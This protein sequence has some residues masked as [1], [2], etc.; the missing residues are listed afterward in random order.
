MDMTD[1]EETTA[2]SSLL[3]TALEA[4]MQRLKAVPLLDDREHRKLQIEASSLLWEQGLKVAYKSLAMAAGRGQI[5]KAVL[6]DEDALQA[7]NLAV[8]TLILQWD[9]D[10]GSLSTFL[11]PRVVGV[12][13]RYRKNDWRQG[14]TGDAR[15][16]AYISLDEDSTDFAD[17]DDSTVFPETELDS[18][19]T[20]AGRLTYSDP[21]SGLEALPIE[22]SREQI[23]DALAT[24]GDRENVAIA[25]FYGVSG[26]AV[27][28]RDIGKWIGVP[29]P[30]AVMRIIQSGLNK[31]REHVTGT[32]K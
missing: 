32:K 15:E 16:I 9:P 29:H 8:G 27:Q 20:A 18:P 12:A 22:A 11:T 24:L 1:H 25:L 31:M 28:L 6:S 30:Q 7:V 17:A 21:P 26:R 4:Y 13:K 14:I 3:G 23:L 19:T 10:K 5:S 2:D